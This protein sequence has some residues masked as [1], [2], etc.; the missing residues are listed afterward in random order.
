MNNIMLETGKFKRA[1]FQFSRDYNLLVEST[2]PTQPP[3]R[4]TV[5]IKIPKKCYEV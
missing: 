1:L 5:N 2:P 4:M 3:H